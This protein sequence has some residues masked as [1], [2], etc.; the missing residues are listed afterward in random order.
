MSRLWQRAG[1]A[2]PGRDQLRSAG[3]ETPLGETKSTRAP[4]WSPLTSGEMQPDD[5]RRQAAR[6]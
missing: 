2:Q 6:G 1:Q 5:C 3:N 4:A